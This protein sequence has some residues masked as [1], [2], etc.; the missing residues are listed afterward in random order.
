VYSRN[1]AALAFYNRIG[2]H[3][4]GERQFRVGAS[5]YFDYILGIDLSHGQD[6]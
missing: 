1:T 4:V 6:Q 2:F 5:E 3:R